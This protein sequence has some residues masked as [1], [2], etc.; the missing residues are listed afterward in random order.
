MIAMIM[1]KIMNKY[2]YVLISQLLSIGEPTDLVFK[3][4][5]LKI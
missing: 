2:A 3:S 4:V 1:Q 5:V